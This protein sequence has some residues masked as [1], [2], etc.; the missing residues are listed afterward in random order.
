MIFAFV[1]ALGGEVT[2]KIENWKVEERLAVWSRSG[3]IAAVTLFIL[4]WTHKSLWF[5]NK[6]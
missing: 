2:K 1:S 3:W 4:L 5:I 6:L